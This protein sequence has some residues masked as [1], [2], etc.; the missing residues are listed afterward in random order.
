MKTF[1]LTLV[2]IGLFSISSYSQEATLSTNAAFLFNDIGTLLSNIEKNTI[3]K[4]SGFERNDNTQQLFRTTYEA[5][6]TVPFEARVFLLDLTYDGVT[7]VGIVYGPANDSGKKGIASLL[8]V[9]NSE[10]HFQLNIDVAG[11]LRFNNLNTMVFPDILVFNNSF[12]LP[13]YR[14]NG[15][16]YLEHKLVTRKKLK[17]FNL[18]SMYQASN[19]YRA[20]LAR[21]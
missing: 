21:E 16:Q 13:T 5:E 14:W 12:E 15:K 8:F 10:G 2:L 17:K 1:S 20:S 18:T 11:E 9:K 4:L 7:E 6:S 19:Q 3:S